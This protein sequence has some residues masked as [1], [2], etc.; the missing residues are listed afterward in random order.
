MELIPDR[1]L[2]VWRE[3][4]ARGYIINPEFVLQV[5]L[6]LIEFRTAVL[7]LTDTELVRTAV[8]ELTDAELV[9]E[10]WKIE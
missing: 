4:S 7:E 3:I 6:E 5:I 10:G 8:I 1:Q 2:Q 9:N